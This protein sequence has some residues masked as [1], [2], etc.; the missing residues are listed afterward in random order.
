MGKARS[1][2]LVPTGPIPAPRLAP[3]PPKR[4]CPRRRAECEFFCQELFIESVSGSSRKT[5][6]PEVKCTQ[7]LSSPCAPGQP[8]KASVTA[9][10]GTSR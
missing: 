8:Q 10:F 2:G 3:T 7:A 4:T 1:Q 5:T 9:A 6:F